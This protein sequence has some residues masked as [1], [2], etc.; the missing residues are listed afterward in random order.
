MTE[1]IHRTR[2][3]DGTRIAGSVH[4]E[5]PPLVLV[6]G[7]LEDGETDWTQLLPLLRDRFTCFLMN[8]RGRGLSDAAEDKTTRRRVQDVMSFV[9]SLG[10]EADVFGESDGGALVLGAAAGTPAIRAVAAHE[11]PVFQV[12][13]D[14]VQTQFEQA[15]GRAQQAAAAGDASR[16]AR[17]FA[18]FVANE[19]ELA[20]L[21]SDYFDAAGRHMPSFFD[22]LEQDAGSDYSPTDPE[23]LSKI[24]APTLVLLGL[25]SAQRDFFTAG[26]DH[27]TG[28][29]PHARVRELPD[30]GH[31]GTTFAA[32]AVAAELVDFF[33]SQPSGV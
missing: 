14:E 27:I 30:S 20:A 23:E 16:A 9:D 22:E 7:S 4:G 25:R 31:W 3:I 32:D 15:V 8:V 26:A 2:S 19:S 18:E 10:E 13:E 21:S 6:H 29:V 33:S 5:G 24:G 11:P 17:V 28:H 12:L 1:R